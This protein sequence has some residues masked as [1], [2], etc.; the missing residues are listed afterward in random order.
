MNVDWISGQLDY[1]YFAFGVFLA[2]QF[3]VCLFLHASEKDRPV[4]P[5]WLLLGL[6]GLTC[7]IHEWLELASSLGFGGGLFSDFGLF[8]MVL[9][10]LF[11]MEFGRR[12]T[13]RLFGA[14]A[15]WAVYG[16]LLLLALSG[17]PYA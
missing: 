9:A 11:L 3:L 12:A 15:A 13:P 10:Y 14:R 7:G 4:K 1:I 5:S 16:T 8:P 17:L 6:F 2:L